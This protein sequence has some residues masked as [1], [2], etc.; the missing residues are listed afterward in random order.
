MIVRYVVWWVSSLFQRVVPVSSSRLADV[1][2]GAAFAL[3][4][5][6]WVS[7]SDAG[8]VGLSLATAV[9]WVWVFS[10][11]RFVWS[12]SVSRSSTLVKDVRVELSLRTAELLLVV[13][14]GFAAVAVLPAPELGAWGFAALAVVQV[15]RI[16]LFADVEPP[17]SVW[18]LV[19][20]MLVSPALSS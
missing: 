9:V 3:F 12:R 6:H 8:T 13:F 11:D 2:F 5:L 20:T 19:R 18:S 4:V 1:Y 7:L 10:M 15:A 14:A 16:E 17:R